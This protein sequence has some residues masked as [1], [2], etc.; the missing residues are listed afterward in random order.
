M[1]RAPICSKLITNVLDVSRIESGKLDI[2]EET[3]EIG[4]L[5]RSAML[6]VRVQADKKSMAIELRLPE[7]PVGLHADP[8]RLRQVLINLLA[9]A[10]KFTPEGGRIIL[11]FEA[12]PEAAIFAVTDTGIGMSPGEIAVATEPFRQIENTLVKRHEGAGL[13]LSL[14]KHMTEMHGGRLEIESEKGAGTTMRVV[15]PASRILRAPK[16]SAAA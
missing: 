16:A 14:A 1:T 6:A 15:L 8:L 3:V 5:V 13:G 11:S 7:E 9:N 2:K 4:E 12:S 10:V